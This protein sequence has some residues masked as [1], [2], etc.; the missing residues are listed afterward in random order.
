MVAQYMKIMENIRQNNTLAEIFL[1]IVAIILT[2]GEVVLR[3]IR[4]LFL[5]SVSLLCQLL[6]ILVFAAVIILTYLIVMAV[7]GAIGP[8]LNTHLH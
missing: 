1:N 6:C 8:W 5:K 4:F 7:S 3:G 2:I